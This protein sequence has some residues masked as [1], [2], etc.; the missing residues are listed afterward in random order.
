[1]AASGRVGRIVTAGAVRR[2][3]NRG[4]RR[5]PLS[6]LCLYGNRSPL[7]DGSF[8]SVNTSLDAKTT[9]VMA[10]TFSGMHA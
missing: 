2:R 10:L 9:A 1:M 6:P 3:P 5:S 7:R 4:A 8:R